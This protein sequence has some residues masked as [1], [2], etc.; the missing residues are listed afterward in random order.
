MAASVAATFTVGQGADARLAFIRYSYLGGGSCDNGFESLCSWLSGYVLGRFGLPTPLIGLSSRRIWAMGLRSFL[1][2]RMDRHWRNSQDPLGGMV[3]RC[4][5]VDV[6]VDVDVDGDVDRDILVMNADG[7]D[8]ITVVSGP[9]DQTRPSWSPDGR[10]LAYVS[11]ERFVGSLAAPENVFIVNI[12]TGQSVVLGDYLVGEGKPIW[13]PDGMRIIFS[14]R[15]TDCREYNTNIVSVSTDGKDRVDLTASGDSDADPVLSPFGRTVLFVRY[16][17]SVSP[18]VEELW[19]VN[20]DGSGLQRIRSDLFGGSKP[21]ISP[22]GGS[23][24]LENYTCAGVSICVLDAVTGLETKPF[25]E[26]SRSGLNMDSPD[27]GCCSGPVLGVENPLIRP[28]VATAGEIAPSP[29]N[30]LAGGGAM[31]ANFNAAGVTVA[32]SELWGGGFQNMIAQAGSKLL[33]AGDN[34]GVHANTG[35]WA[36]SSTGFKSFQQSREVASIAVD[37]TDTNRVWAATTGGVYYSTDN[38]TNWEFKADQT[39]MTP[40]VPNFRG[41]NNPGNLPLFPNHPRATGQLLIVDGGSPTYL[42]AASAEDGLWRSTDNGENWERIALRNHRLRSV[43]QH[44]SGALYIASLGTN[45]NNANGGIYEVCEPGGCVAPTACNGSCSVIKLSAGVSGGLKMPEEL[46]FGPNNRLWCACGD[47]GVWRT[48]IGDFDNWADFS[49]SPNNISLTIAPDKYVWSAIDIGDFDG[50][51]QLDVVAGAVVNDE[52]GSTEKALQWTPVNFVSWKDVLDNHEEVRDEPV[53]DTSVKWWAADKDNKPIHQNILVDKKWDTGF[54]KFTE[55][56][57]DNTKDILYITGRS[58][59]WRMRDGSDGNDWLKNETPCAFVEGLASTANRAIDAGPE[60]GTD[61]SVIIGNTDFDAISSTNGLQATA[62]FSDNGGIVV[63]NI[64][65]Q[66][67]G[68]DVDYNSGNAV[69][70]ALIGA[71]GRDKNDVSQGDVYSAVAEDHNGTSLGL[72]VNW[73]VVGVGAATRPN[74][75]RTRYELAVVTEL[76]APA[77][78]ANTTP[79]PSADRGIWR[80]ANGLWSKRPAAIG[81]SS[82]DTPFTRVPIEWGRSTTNSTGYTKFVFLLDRETGI[83]RSENWGE[84]W[85]RIWGDSLDQHFPTSVNGSSPDYIGFMAINPTDQDELVFTSDLGLYQIN[86]AKS[87]TLTSCIED[88][89]MAAGSPKFGPVAFSPDDGQLVVSTR[90]VD[91]SMDKPE[92]WVRDT[93]GSFQQKVIEDPIFNSTAFALTDMAVTH[94]RDIF[95]SSRGQGV[96][97]ISG[98]VSENPPQ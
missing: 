36:P 65:G 42:Y 53:C 92:I 75:S 87:C 10:S 67:V 94:S 78:A 86:S 95:L 14:A 1:S 88:E 82:G 13:S 3:T 39:T 90:V 51:G 28:G 16:P 85:V 89:I 83:W 22:D 47:K 97:V 68:F 4:G 73:R 30:L 38:G 46:V 81:D 24:V 9:G 45:D 34:S 17:S 32:V 33:M 74:A 55:D 6:D 44:S 50:A 19:S 48:A 18:S 49:P 79:T 96:I 43:V 23:I 54:I 5:D 80:R 12:D 58:G 15:C 52:D 61:N 40:D 70:Y 69:P 26:P 66:T 21:T 41:N 57:S 84:D 77:T 72:D 27:W 93:T 76:S 91:G 25:G 35:Q 62:N 31:T 64:P 7:S 37:P 8:V 29:F 56:P 98:A 63:H 2:G 60:G 11:D 71:G 59:A 20:T